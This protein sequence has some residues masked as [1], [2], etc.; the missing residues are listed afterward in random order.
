MDAQMP[1]NKLKS[2]VR[3]P[4]NLYLFHTLVGPRKL[5]YLLL[6]SEAISDARDTRRPVALFV[7]KLE[8]ELG[9]KSATLTVALGRRPLRICGEI[10]GPIRAGVDLRSPAV[11]RCR[12]E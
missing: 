12:P 10:R 1:V 5:R 11:G 6:S 3:T 7:Q 9:R 4:V 8:V 2:L